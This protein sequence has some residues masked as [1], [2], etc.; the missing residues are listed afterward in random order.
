MRRLP[1]SERDNRATVRSLPP[2][3]ISRCQICCVSADGVNTTIGSC[4]PYRPSVD[5]ARELPVALSCPRVFP[6]RMG[7]LFGCKIDNAAI[8][9][10][11]GGERRCRE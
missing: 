1:S 5:L 4:C 3:E 2:S 10:A 6:D 9:R 8:H 11:V 7:R